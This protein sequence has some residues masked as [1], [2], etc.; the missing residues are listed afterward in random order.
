MGLSPSTQK[1]I[2]IAI[3]WL[4]GAGLIKTKKVWESDTIVDE[5]G[6]PKGSKPK[7][8]I[9]YSIVL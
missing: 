2:R 6:L 4:E 9:Y 8:K 3:K 7:S 5:N 1:V